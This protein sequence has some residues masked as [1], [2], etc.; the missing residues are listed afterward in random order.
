ML[1]CYIG[2]EFNAT[3]CDLLRD[4][5]WSDPKWQAEQ[6]VGYDYPVNET[7]PPPGVGSDL[8][9]TQC[10]LG[11]SPKYA[12]NATSEADISKGILFA[13]KTNLRVVIKSSGHDF[14]QR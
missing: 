14:L 13:K 6:P 10:Q 1:P 2:P 9:S 8:S 3:T 12:I 11:N 4:D 5:L 7:C